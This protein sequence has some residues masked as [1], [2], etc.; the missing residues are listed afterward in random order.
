MKLIKVGVSLALAALFTLVFYKQSLGLNILIYEWTLVGIILWL[1]KKD[2][3]TWAG[4]SLLLAFVASG[5]AVVL[6]NSVFAKA[7]NIMLGLVLSGY[8]FSGMLFTVYFWPVQ[9][10]VAM[11]VNQIAFVKRLF[12]F[13][14]GWIGRKWGRRIAIGAPAILVLGVFFVLYYNSSPWL[15]DALNGA[16]TALLDSIADL[17]SK[18]NWIAFWLFVFGLLVT[19]MF[20][21]NPKLKLVEATR[22]ILNLKR[23]RSV[24]KNRGGMLALLYEYKTG[25]S[26]LLGLNVLLAIV[27]FLDI[28]NIWFG[29][30]FEGQFLKEL[31]HEGTYTLIFSVLLS[32]AVVLYFFRG[33]LNFYKRN[34]LLR[35]LTKVWISQNALLLVSVM[36][37]NSIYIQHYSLAYKRIGVFMFLIATA[38]ALLTLVIKVERVR[39][40]VFFSRVNTLS[41]LSLL[42][43]GCFINW[44]VWIARYNMN[45]YK[46]AF[47]HLDFMAGLSYKALPEL[48]YSL[49][50]IERIKAEQPAHFDTE[51]SSIRKRVQYMEPAEFCEEIADKKR[52]FTEQYSKRHWL[53]W[54]LADEKAYQELTKSGERH[55]AFIEQ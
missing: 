20:I 29:F 42:L 22:E 21:W 3:Q 38:V 30:Q 41:V 25:I 11:V 26:L 8:L 33:N 7:V 31:V 5:I 23:K 15:K 10:M 44:D 48:D 40:L 4:R 13:K 2:C 27:N 50:D 1:F 17:F 16:V 37:R 55:T 28:K 45:H 43:V 6:F 53:S 46:T 14:L 47:L 9:S 52:S 54:N 51:S 19:N 36:V 32:I 35:L 34:K 39:S 49:E 18:V 24:V 12:S